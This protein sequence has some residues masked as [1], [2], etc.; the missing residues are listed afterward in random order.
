MSLARTPVKSSLIKAFI[1]MLQI[2]FYLPHLFNVKVQ[3]FSNPH[4]VQTGLIQA[5]TLKHRI[6][7]IQSIMVPIYAQSDH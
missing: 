3:T 2:R 5:I 6:N 1:V 4:Y 7:V